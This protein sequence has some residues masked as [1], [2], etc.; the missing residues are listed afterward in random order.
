M[1][2]NLSQTF[3]AI[4]RNDTDLE[5]L[6]GALAP[7][8]QVVSAGGGS[9]DELLALVD[10]TFAS[11]VFVG[12]DR[13]HVVAQSALIEGA[14]EAKPM[15]AIV[16]LGDGMD[17]QLVLNAMRA[18]ARDFVAYGS[19]SSEVSGL[20]RR[21]GKRLPTVAP[22]T[23]LGGLTVLYGAQTNAD[24][25]LIANHMAQ[26][27]Q[28]SGQQTLLLDLGLP[29]GDS[30]A[31]LGLE[32]SFHFGDAVRHLRR[33]DAT[34]IDSA[35]TSN[36][37]GL[38]IL[39][40]ASHDEPLERTSAAELYMLLSALRQ[41]FQHIV[42]NLTGQPDSEALR[43]FVSHC[44]KLLWY[45]DQNVLD[46]RRNLA[47]LNLWREKGLKLDHARLLID[48]YLR[49]VA[50]DADTLGKSFGME[51]LAILAFSPEVRLNA[52]N[53]GVSLFELAPREGLTQSLR[54]LGERL[55]KRSE[56][57]A[58][59]KTGWFNRLRGAQ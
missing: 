59:P 18:G 56:G 4:T 12:L 24:G 15:L 38:R 54:T 25:A 2:Q 37:T 17:N 51:V 57:L 33:L 28:K 48:R 22:S 42:V 55:A 41:H 34:L 29:R 26:V 23:Q 20:V 19:R 50:P 31:L 52:K 40:Y 32:S 27:V 44:D 1:S 35:F 49:N 14:L 16:A 13:E 3:L 5:W 45:T 43:T 9:L 30:L 46:C 11:L 8:G 53:Q 21:L 58:K 39:A 7:L 10:V 36:E 6:Q 47:V